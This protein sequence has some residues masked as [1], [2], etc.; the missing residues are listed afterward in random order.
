M[1]HHVPPH[2]SPA[3]LQAEAS[4]STRHLWL[5]VAGEGL[6][7]RLAVAARAVIAIGGGYAVAA[8][9]QAALS[10]MLPLPR[11][12]ATITAT[13]TALVLYAV[14]AMWVFAAR[15]VWMA[16]LGLVI[17]A[18]PFGAMLLVHFYTGSAS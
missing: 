11:P 15:T 1:T 7:Y 10:V 17:V 9:S 18:L 3:A 4:P 13:L 16:M 5:P 6:R 12:E 14:A 8:L 2:S